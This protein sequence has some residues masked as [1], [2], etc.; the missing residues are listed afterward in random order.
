MLYQIYG[1][2][3]GVKALRGINKFLHKCLA[4]AR[5]LNALPVQM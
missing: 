2:R 3:A 4:I 1:S 5:N